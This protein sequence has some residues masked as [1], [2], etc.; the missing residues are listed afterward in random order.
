MGDTSVPPVSE[1][2][3]VVSP[4]ITHPEW[5]RA[6][7]ASSQFHFSYVEQPHHNNEI[8]IKLSSNFKITIFTSLFSFYNCFTIFP[9]NPSSIFKYSFYFAYLRL[10]VL[11]F[12][13][14]LWLCT[15]LSCCSFLS[16][17]FFISLMLRG[18]IFLHLLI[19]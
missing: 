9:F 2:T 14:L 16:V 1:R 6:G 8:C 12:F 18:Q 7:Q 10:I 13:I 17:R 15:H 11:F 19:F 3:P 4:I 5:L